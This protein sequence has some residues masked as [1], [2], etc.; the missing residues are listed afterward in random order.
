MLIVLRIL[1]GLVGIGALICW[2]I[3]LI[4]LFK[5][6][7]VGFGILGI[8]CALFA[9]IYGWMKAEEWGIKQIML[10]WT[11]LIVVSIILN[12]IAGAIVGASVM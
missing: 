10:I 6:K 4:Q 3:V 1:S 8:I 7:G 9:L 5:Q 2:V 11:A 12:A